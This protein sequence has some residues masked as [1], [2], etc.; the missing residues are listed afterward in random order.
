[1]AFFLG[2]VM[3]I[4]IGKIVKAQ[5]IKGEVKVEC[6]LDS[7]VA[8]K[9]PSVL[10]TG[11]KSQSVRN[12]RAAKDCWYMSFDGVNDRNT[13]ETLRG[14]EVYALRSDVQI[15]DGSYFVQDVV[16]CDVFLDNGDKV[17]EVKEVLQYGSADVYVVQ[18]GKK[19][20]SFPWLKNLVNKVDTEGKRITLNA[21]RFS[22]VVVYD[23]D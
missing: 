22:Q 12:I 11:T 15:A 20:L 18:N 17:G 5:G 21:D 3:K 10:Y 16:G 7:P 13:A 1:M 2:Y 8:L 19:S 9:K 23:E 14:W 6:Y 4:L